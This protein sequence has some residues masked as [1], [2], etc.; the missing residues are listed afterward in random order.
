MCLVRQV[1]LYPFFV[2]NLH[3]HSLCPCSD[4]D[5]KSHTSPLVLD[6]WQFG[7]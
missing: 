3:A 1:V 7:R 2:I 4:E 6:M 5:F